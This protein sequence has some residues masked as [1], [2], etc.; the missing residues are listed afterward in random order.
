ML[1]RHLQSARSLGSACELKKTLASHR[2]LGMT[3]LDLS[4]VNSIRNI[5]CLS[6]AVQHQK[7]PTK[8]QEDRNGSSVRELRDFLNFFVPFFFPKLCYE[9]VAPRCARSSKI[10]NR[11]IG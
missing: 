8:E 7:I 2:P 9:R 10:E 4:R 5:C 11:V 6:S 1:R 3:N